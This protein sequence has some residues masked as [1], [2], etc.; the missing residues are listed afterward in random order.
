M[1]I[2]ALT[3]SC[4]YIPGPRRKIEEDFFLCKF[5]PL[6]IKSE[7]Y[8]PIR[9]DK[10]VSKS[11]PV[12]ARGEAQGEEK[13]TLTRCGQA[14]LPGGAAPYLV[15]PASHIEKRRQVLITQKNNL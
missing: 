8:R 4:D 12:L 1:R 6:L 7:L 5:M 13:H 14:S 2:H 9:H 10:H 15:L 3:C 11:F